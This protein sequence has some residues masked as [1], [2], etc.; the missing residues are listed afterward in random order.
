MGPSYSLS[1]PGAAAATAGGGYASYALLA[2]DKLFN[3]SCICAQDFLIIGFERVEQSLSPDKF[4][5]TINV[6]VVAV[7]SL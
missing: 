4:L 7:D 3:G 2:T 5:E 6:V 1:P